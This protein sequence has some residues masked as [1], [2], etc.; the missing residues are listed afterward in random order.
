M[1]ALIRRLRKLEERLAPQ[2]DTRMVV[3]FEGPGSERFAQPREE[4]MD[5]NRTTLVVQFV[6]SDGNGRPAY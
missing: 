3:R 1:K 4:D 6:A 5:E 2:V